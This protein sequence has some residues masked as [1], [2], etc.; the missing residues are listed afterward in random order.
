MNHSMENAEVVGVVADMHLNDR[1]NNDVFVPL[2]QVPGFW[3]DVVVRTTGNPDALSAP[4][5]QAIYRSSPDTLIEHVSP[6]QAIISNAYGLERAQSFLTAL[7]A[8]LGG[9]VALLGLYALLNQYVA[10]RTRELGVCLALG[11]SPD[12]LF[13]SVFGR[14]M[15]L[16]TAGIAIGFV[17]A[18]GAVRALRG[19]VFGLDAPVIWFFLLVA[20]GIAA[21]AA[22]VIATSARRVLVIDPLLSIRQM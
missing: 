9:I 11:A 12:R 17:V 6:M 5:R 20:L 19:Q 16:S 18:L 14:G 1:R 8:A 15:Q 3:A 2:A 7:V 10:R 13:W 21:I 4:I 22:M